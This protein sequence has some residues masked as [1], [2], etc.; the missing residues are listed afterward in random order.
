MSLSLSGRRI[1]FDED[2]DDDVDEWTGFF[3]C[4]EIRKV[5]SRGGFGIG[6]EYP[7]LMPVV[8]LVE[9]VFFTLLPIFGPPSSISRVQFFSCSNFASDIR[10]LVASYT[11][12]LACIRILYWSAPKESNE[13]AEVCCTHS[14][15]PEGPSISVLLEREKLNR[16]WPL[17]TWL[18]VGNERKPSLLLNCRVGDSWIFGWF[19]I[20][21]SIALA[22][23]SVNLTNIKLLLS[24]KLVWDAN[25]YWT[26]F[27]RGAIVCFSIWTHEDLSFIIF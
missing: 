10:F 3:G 26:P 24:F 16:C 18:P 8:T 7:K 25:L 27:S 14:K 13:L 17:D 20:Y 19:L 1:T 5:P 22:A 23:E 12:S 9:V 2:D 11:S 21:S 15:E 4:V 6:A